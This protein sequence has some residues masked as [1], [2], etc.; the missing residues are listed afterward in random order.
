MLL[1]GIQLGRYRLLRVI[2]S[3]GMA[4]VYHAEDTTMAR[5]VAMKVVRTE[6]T[7]L[8]DGKKQADVARLFQRE[9]LAIT[10]LNHRHILPLY[11]F[12]EQRVND[13]T[14]AYMVMPFL[15]EGSLA[16]WLKRHNGAC[17][18]APQEVAVVMQQAA[19]ALQYAHENGLIHQDVKPSNFLVRNQARTARDLD[20][21]LADFGI[22]RFTTATATSS[23]SVRG[24]PA[25][26]APEQWE[27]RPVPATDQYALA[28][29]AYQLLTG[30]TPFQGR[31]E[32]VMHQH[33]M[34]QPKPPSTGDARL[35]PALD[36]VILLALEKKPADRFPTILGFARAFQQALQP[37]N[38]LSI[39]PSMPPTPLPPMVATIP[40]NQDSPASSS[41][42]NPITPPPF[43]NGRDIRTSLSINATLAKAGGNQPVTLSDGRVVSVPIPSD[44]RNGQVVYLPNLGEPSTTGGQS[45]ALLVTL[46]VPSAFSARALII[47]GLVF[48]LI[49]SGIVGLA[50]HQNDIT[51]ANMAAA[52]TTTASTATLVANARAMSATATAAVVNDPYGPA[53]GTLALYDSL[54]APS[55]WTNYSDTAFGGACQFTSGSYHITQSKPNRIYPCTNSDRAFS[56]F[57]FDVQMTITKGDCGGLVFRDDA[58]SNTFYEF[59]VCQDGTY[60]LYLYKGDKA[61]DVTTL[62]YGKSSAIKQGLGQMNLIA[63]VANG[64]TLTLYVNNE[65]IDQAADTTY[66]IG[67]LGFVA[68]SIQNATEVVYNKAR[69]WQI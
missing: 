34:V 40:S 48:L 58:S 49:I 1:E 68:R 20:L 35:T 65:K 13:F 47:I 51:Q 41:R 39:T 14:L 6:Y 9:M 55:H 42:P 17:L 3:G 36:A 53:N 30:N 60:D 29:M 57:A 38:Q 23:Q 8:Q 64:K 26:M 25:Y 31:L 63:A 4:D 22:V 46:T 32:Q 52:A 43:I 27:G 61:S 45:G 10:R 21:L 66:S 7:P 19:E 67:Y 24:T 62:A 44:T 69:V 11:D 5:Y 50:V 56:N 12:G 54:E 33:L 37:S 15:T 28:I 16:D 59:E 2:G 18:L